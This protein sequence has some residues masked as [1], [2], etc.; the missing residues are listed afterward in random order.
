MKTQPIENILP[1]EIDAE[2]KVILNALSL[3]VSEIVN[4]GTHIL[5]FLN[6]K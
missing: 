2:L 1:Q 4:F 6:E 5:L 3:T